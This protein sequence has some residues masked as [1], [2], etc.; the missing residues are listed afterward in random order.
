[1]VC[2]ALLAACG[3]AEKMNGFSERDARARAI[4]PESLDGCSV[5]QGRL[6]LEVG[7]VLVREYPQAQ[8]ADAFRQHKQP[9]LLLWVRQPGGAPGATVIT[10]MAAP[11]EYRAGDPIRF[12]E[13]RRL[14]DQPLRLL[15][16]RKLE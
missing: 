13:G 6:V 1:M 12:F 14:L 11:E 3:G 9:L 10:P 7:S 15:A 5:R 4:P 8:V 16:G 2:A